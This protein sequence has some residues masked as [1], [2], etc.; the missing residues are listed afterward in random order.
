MFF[1]EI[2]KKVKKR[3]KRSVPLHCCQ[4]LTLPNVPTRRLLPG[5]PTT[6]TSTATVWGLNRRRQWLLGARNWITVIIERSDHSLV[7]YWGL[8]F[9]W[10]LF[11]TFWYV[12][13]KKR[14]KSSFLKSEKNEKYVFSNTGCKLP[15]WEMGQSPS[16]R[17]CAYWS[18]KVQLCWQQFL[19]IFL[20]TNYFSAQ[21]QTSYHTAG[22]VPHTAAPY[23]RSISPGRCHH[24]S[25]EVGAYSGKGCYVTHCNGIHLPTWPI[26]CKYG[27]IHP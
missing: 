22:P 5:N 2:W 14:K 23:D 8:N 21:K 20:R 18:Q 13:S 11:T 6:A 15:Q 10:W 7:T 25:M 17:F 1:F 16:R 24:C 27:V 19:L 26:M 3:K 4:N 12:I 9:C